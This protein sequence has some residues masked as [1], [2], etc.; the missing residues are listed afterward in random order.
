LL[1][2][3]MVNPTTGPAILYFA[4]FDVFCVPRRRDLRAPGSDSWEKG[5]RT[6]VRVDG[7]GDG[8]GGGTSS[9]SGCNS[10]PF[11]PP[12]QVNKKR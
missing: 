1:V 9:S 11:D 4:A 7:G 5:R 8:G 12:T 6:K 10:V 3:V 2:R